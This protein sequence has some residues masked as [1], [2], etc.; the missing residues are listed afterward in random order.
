MKLFSSVV[1]LTGLALGSLAY[2]QDPAQTTPPAPQQQPQQQQQQPPTDTGKV[3]VTGC[4]MKGTDSAQYTIT[5]Q[6]TGEKVPFSGPAQLEKYL[7][8]TVKVTGTLVAQGQ[9][10]IFKPES[11]NQIANTCEKGQ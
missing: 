10:K 8:Q 7:N 4:L 1:L 11:I 5:D 3:S 6:K 2:G 9:E